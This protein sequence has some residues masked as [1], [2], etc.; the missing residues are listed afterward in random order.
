[1]SD[2]EFM[3]AAMEE[4]AAAAAA[5]EVPVGAVAVC[6]GVIIARGRNCVESRGAVDGH[7][8]FELMRA[9]CQQRG[10]WRLEDCEIFVTKEP[11]FMCT[12]M[13]INARAKR[14]VY[15]FADPAAGGCGGSLD[16]CA[17]PGIY[18]ILKSLP[19]SV[20]MKHWSNFVFFSKKFAKK[21]K[22][23]LEKLYFRVYSMQ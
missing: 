19:G 11:C 5:G 9:L 16:L 15:G 22:N 6:D 10:D 13:L 7:A 2:A 1:M 21:I 14:I 20:R 8:E 3:A 17:H 23:A 4:A 18:G 12:G